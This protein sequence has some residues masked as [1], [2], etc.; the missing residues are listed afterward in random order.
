VCIAKDFRLH[1]FVV[2]GL[3]NFE[4]YVSNDPPTQ[5]SP[6]VITDSYTLCGHYKGPVNASQK[7][8]VICTPFSQKFRFVIVRSADTLHEKLCMTEVAVYAAKSMQLRILYWCFRCC[9]VLLCV[10]MAALCNRG[11]II[12]LPCSFFLS[13]FLSIFLFYSSPNLSGHRVDVYHTLAHGVALVR[14]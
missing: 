8:T 6:I 4:V 2:N 9:I 12:F 14:I 7:I 3:D 1:C 13:F 5:G 10:F 11:A